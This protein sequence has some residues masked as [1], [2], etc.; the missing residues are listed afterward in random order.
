[1]SRL[2]VSRFAN[3]IGEGAWVQSAQNLSEHCRAGTHSHPE[4][5]PPKSLQSEIE[6]T[7]SDAL[8]HII[9]TLTQLRQRLT[10]Q[11]WD[12]WKS[13]PLPGNGLW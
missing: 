6:D 11:P 12:R 2:L 4:N 10:G 1:M 13:D 5:R 3:V 9:S 7:R 8:P